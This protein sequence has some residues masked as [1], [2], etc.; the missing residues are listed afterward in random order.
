MTK[1]RIWIAA[2]VAWLL[3][4]FSVERFHEPINFA[5]FVY[6]LASAAAITVVIVPRRNTSS[7]RFL[8]FGTLGL[9][10]VLK[11]VLGYQILGPSLPITVTEATALLITVLLAQRIHG[12]YLTHLDRRPD[13]VICLDATGETM[14][15]RKGEGTVDLLNRRREDYQ[16]LRGAVTHFR[17]VDADRP[18]DVVTADV[19]QHICD[20]P[21][22]S[23]KPAPSSRLAS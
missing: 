19:K 4:F 18:L 16:G 20:F 9:H 8:L 15:A 7:L 6:V 21:V 11:V 22:D 17:L 10:L 13:L 23:A 14:F 5:S 1:L 3:V 12:F 2:T